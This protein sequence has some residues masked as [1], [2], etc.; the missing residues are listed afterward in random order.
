MPFGSRHSDAS[1]SM[2]MT[3]PRVIKNRKLHNALATGVSYSIRSINGAPWKIEMTVPVDH[4]DIEKLCWFIVKGLAHHHWQV[5]LGSEHIVRACFLNEVGRQWFDP[6]FA[7]AARAKVKQDWGDGVFAYEGVQSRDCPDLT[8][9]KMSIYG[10]EISGDKYPK[11]ERNSLIYG[12]S[13][14][15]AWPATA[16]LL[17]ILGK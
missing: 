13:A 17:K 1:Q 6:F 3:I 7:G 12:I 11:G 9:W 2:A 8:L 10:A 15:K 14:P 5:A 16:M 4:A